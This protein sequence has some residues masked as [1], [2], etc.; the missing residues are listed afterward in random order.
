MT[1]T[2]CQPSCNTCYHTSLKVVPLLFEIFQRNDQID[3]E[4]EQIYDTLL[5]SKG[6]THR[7]SLGVH[8][9]KMAWRDSKIIHDPDR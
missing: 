6:L 4:N 5:C 3:F 2:F 8:Y 7:S 1:G 9:A